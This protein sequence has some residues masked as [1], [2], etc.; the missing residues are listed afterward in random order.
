[1]GIDKVVKFGCSGG[2]KDGEEGGVGEKGA[3]RRGV[4]E[5]RG[6]TRVGVGESLPVP[7]T[8]IPSVKSRR[9]RSLMEGTSLSISLPDLFRGY[10]S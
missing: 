6:E 8:W 4:R 2:V 5:A 9:Y 3:R 7:V 10:K 1:V